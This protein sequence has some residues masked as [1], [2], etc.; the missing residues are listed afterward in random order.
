[1][2]RQELEWLRISAIGGELVRITQSPSSGKATA[3][4]DADACHDMNSVS[5]VVIGVDNCTQRAD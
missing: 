3:V 4:I 2:R 5:M 1:M